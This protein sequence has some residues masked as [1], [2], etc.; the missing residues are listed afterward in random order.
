MCIRDRC[1]VHGIIKE[2]TSVVLML[3]ESEQHSGIF[4]LKSVIGGLNGFLKA[5]ETESII[6]GYFEE[7]KYG[8]GKVGYKAGKEFLDYANIFNLVNMHHFSNAE[9]NLKEMLK[10]Q[11][12]DILEEKI[13]YPLIK[14][15]RKDL[16]LK[17]FK[18]SQG[19]LVELMKT[20]NN[21]LVQLTLLKF[22]H[23][24]VLTA[25]ADFQD[26]EAAKSYVGLSLIH[27]CRC[28]RYA[29]CRSRWSP[30]H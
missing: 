11:K 2:S 10:T 9:I 5:V 8:K 23:E 16:F 20:S 28:R 3:E 4:D 1:R 6:K 22:I 7:T 15:F 13:I 27:I 18:E 19:T 14:R 25:D 29:V 24:I 21:F 30:Y 12:G 26:E 17:A